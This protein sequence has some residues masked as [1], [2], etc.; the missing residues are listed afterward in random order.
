MRKILRAALVLMCISLS[1]LLFACGAGG[2]GNAPVTKFVTVTLG[3]NS[4]AAIVGATVSLV[5]AQGAVQYSATTSDLGVAAFTVKGGEEKT[6]VAKVTALPEGK[7]ASAEQLAAT[8]SIESLT[9]NIVLSLPT[10]VFNATF[11]G[12]PVA[13]LTVSLHRASNNALVATAVTD[14]NGNAIFT[15][16]PGTYKVIA[17]PGATD[18]FE[19]KD[20]L[21]KATDAGNTVSLELTAAVGLSES[22]PITYTKIKHEFT[23]SVRAGSVTWYKLAYESG[24]YIVFSSANAVVTYAGNEYKAGA[25][26]NFV[27]VELSVPSA[28]V[29]EALISVKTADGKAADV[30]AE[31]TYPV[32]TVNNPIAFTESLSGIKLAAGEKIYYLYTTDH[33]VKVTVTASAS[34]VA[35]KNADSGKAI[36]GECSVLPS[37]SLCIELSATTAVTTALEVSARNYRM[38][39]LGDSISTFAGY[40]NNTLHN[41]SLSGNA[42]VYYPTDP[43]ITDEF[44]VEDTYWKKIMNAFSFDLCVNNSQGGD[45]VTANG[46]SRAKNLH[47]KKGENPDVILI[48]LGTNDL[49]QQEE[50]KITVD[51]FKTKYNEMLDAIKTKYP[52][53]QVFCMRLLTEE[54]SA[55]KPDV[56]ADFNTV[57]HECA[58]AHGYESISLGDT[59]WNYLSDTYKDATLRVHP[60]KGGMQK[61]ADAAIPQIEEKLK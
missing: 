8:H 2:G 40:S 23:A 57:I 33:P 21:V 50:Q 41:A 30:S 3:D 9:A 38:S 11:G 61:M 17:T 47:N 60:N 58:T 48:Y 34:T 5:D 18:P 55:D 20:A 28:D 6:L 56:L 49:G 19:V 59:G 14:A 42:S 24:A 7:L 54:R 1:F 27:K 37:Q 29:G 32:G 44:T 4:G 26:E 10:Y 15:A 46:V 39:L 12:Q 22:D 52:D 16:D 43:D 53:A 13:G 25:G 35:V 45:M 51:R 36:T 31:L